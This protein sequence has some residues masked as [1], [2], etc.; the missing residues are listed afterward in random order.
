MIK[1]S[2][3]LS[4]GFKSFKHTI[5][6]IPKCYFGKAETMNKSKLKLTNS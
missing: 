2:K 1:Y 5:V 3:Y 4:V 6:K